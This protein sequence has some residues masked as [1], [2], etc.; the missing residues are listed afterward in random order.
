LDQKGEPWQI[1]EPIAEFAGT[2]LSKRTFSV[3]DALIAATAQAHQMTLATR[4]LK[5]FQDVE[6]LVIDPWA[7]T[8]S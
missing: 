6:I 5:D 3:A 4:N 1:D 8:Q 2:A 7:T